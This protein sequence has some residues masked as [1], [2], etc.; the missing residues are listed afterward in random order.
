MMYSSLLDNLRYNS[1]DG[2]LYWNKNINSRARK[3]K[4]AGG[5]EPDGYRRIRFKQRNYVAHKVVWYL[6]NKTVVL[7]HLDHING[8]RLDNR[9]E[10]LRIATTRQNA[11]NR[12][13]HRDGNL[14]G[15][16]RHTA[17]SGNKVGWYASIH[18]NGKA[19]YLGYYQTE[20]EA[21]TAYLF[22]AILYG[23]EVCI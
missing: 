5:V 13:R 19:L 18:I 2:N 15:C 21:H 1:E 7:G 14:P 16:Y 12:K 17:K 4:I 23:V 20:Q 10:N 3:D 6:H 22:A 11:L 8:N 9:I